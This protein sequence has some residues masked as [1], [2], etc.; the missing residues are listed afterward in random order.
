MTVLALIEELVKWLDPAFAAAGY[1]IIVAAVLMERSILL[2]LIVPG[3]VIIALGGI[4]A[5]RG[6]L[7]L[8]W[9]IVIATVAAITGESVG[10]WLGRRYG[11]RLIRRLPLVNRLEGRL[12]DAQKY[13]ARHGGKTVA[14]GRYAT[15]AGAFVPFVAG[16]AN[17]SYPRF[18]AFD[19]PAIA[20]W[21]TAITLLGYFFEHQLDTVDTILSRFGWF[22][23]GAIVLFVAGRILWK[24]FHAEDEAG[25]KS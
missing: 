21:A 19:V 4:Y 23:L 16:L 7:T 17:M 1:W 25:T 12:E 2:G 5:A 3:D 15:A 13:F 6:D 8:T 22:M 11:K 9:V 10:Y 20:V 24:R 18:L 14:I